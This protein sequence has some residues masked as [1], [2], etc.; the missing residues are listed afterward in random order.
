[1]TGAAI[2]NGAV[3]LCDG[4]VVDVADIGVVS[5]RHSGVEV[6]YFDGAFIPALINAH[7]HLELSHLTGLEP[8][9]AEK[10]FTDWVEELLGR[11]FDQPVSDDKILEE[12]IA[13]ARSQFESGVAL[14]GDIGNTTL[15]GS[16]VPEEGGLPEIY[17]ML[18]LL[19]SS[20]EAVAAAYDT[21]SELSPE[22]S[23]VPHAPYSTRPELLKKIKQ[24]CD[25]NGSI[26]SIHTAETSA[27]TEF[28]SSATGLFHDF[29]VKRGSWTD[30]YFEHGSKAQSTIEY[31]S[32]LGLLNEKTLLV[33][34][35]H[36]TESDMEL[37]KDSGAH[38]C[39]CPGSNSFLH[40]GK[41][42][43]DKMIDSGLLPAIG[44]DSIVSNLHLDMWEEMKLI[45]SDYPSIKA[46]D[47]LRMATT[48]GA[49]AF[50]CGDS[51]GAIAEGKS[52]DFL[53]IQGDKIKNCITESDLL[54]ML[55]SNG[56]PEKIEWIQQTFVNPR[57]N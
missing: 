38:I 10:T 39:V 28:V 42:P 43:V 37:I 19:G 3:V 48:A 46:L 12:A 14:M 4:K 54:N 13:Q 20:K 33:H 45:R 44:T 53:H 11:R 16:I 6:E 29:L 24:R 18:E 57:S 5:E 27:E 56:R 8:L 41:A 26:F 9:V 31:F 51:Y 17:H 35:V 55:V 52:G 49:D 21:L 32:E 47:I 23:V 7:T 34:C 50:G 30:D 40:S 2:Q 15:G 22:T 36:V 1:M 25:E